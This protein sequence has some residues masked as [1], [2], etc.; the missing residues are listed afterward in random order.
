M[1]RKFLTL[2]T[3]HISRETLDRLNA[4][5]H[6][7]GLPF[8]GGITSYGWFA[9]CHDENLGQGDDEIPADLWAIM[10]YARS[11]GCEYVMLDADGPRFRAA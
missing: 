10:V 2:S 7:D 4:I 9:Y 3:A 8:A 6:P 11:I 5:D 1:I